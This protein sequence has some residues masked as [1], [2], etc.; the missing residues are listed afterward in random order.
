[1]SGRFLGGDLRRADAYLLAFLVLAAAA[2]RFA[3]LG[4]QSFWVDET[5]TARLV[6]SSFSDMIGALPSSES[7]PPLYYVLAWG[8]ARAFGSG[9]AALR[10][11]SALLGTL[12]VPVAYAAGQALV[13]RRTGLFAAALAT[14]SP[15][16]VWYS[17][18]ARAYALFIFLS[19]VSLLFFARALDEP[20]RRSLGWWAGTSALALLTHYFAAFLVAAEAVFLLHRHRRRD[21]Y[22]ST[23]A[24]VVVGLAVAPLAAY[25]AKYA[26]SK[27]IQEVDLAQRVEETVGQLL[28]PSRPSIWAG[29]GVPEGPPSLWVLGIV[30]LGVGGTASVVLTRGRQRRGALTGLSLGLTAVLA[31]I[32]ISL[33][34]RAFASG[35]GDVFLYRNVI[36]AWLPLTIVIA[37]AMAAPRCRW[38]GTAGFAG[39]CAASLAVLSVNSTTAHLQRDDWRLVASAVEGPARAIVLS[40]SWEV[41]GLEF[42]A[43]DLGTRDRGAPIREIQVVARRW[44]PSY[45]PTVQTLDPPPP[46]AEGETRILQN[47]R[48]TVFRAATPVPVTVAELSRVRPENASRVVLGR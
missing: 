17:Q 48:L 6:A 37:A 45:S 27:W 18:E 24:V 10:S 8:W 38:L 44:T 7:A 1:L 28:V 30:L 22:L 36:C 43:G 34:A 4:S 41:A 15:L 25:Q 5:I 21:V 20:S 23:M 16:L 31:P 47:F 32:V 26:S 2:V 12:T 29:A 9:E 42:Y 3:A 33:G 11:L 46:F 19:A 39:L 35:R 13:S 14:V 40:P